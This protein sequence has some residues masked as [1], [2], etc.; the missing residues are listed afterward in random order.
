MIKKF[1]NY[2]SILLLA[3]TCFSLNTKAQVINTEAKLQQYS[4]RI[5]D[6]TKL[7][8]SVHQPIKEHVNFP[9]LADTLTGK[10]QIVSALKPDTTFD[11]NDHTQATI[12]H[13]YIITCFDEGTYTIPPFLLGT[14]GGVLKT[15]DLTLQVKT[16]KV[17]TTK[18]IYDIK[19][20]LVVSYTLW[21]WL[22]DNWILIVVILAILLA[23]AAIIWYLKNRPK[24]IPLI[25]VVKPVIPVHTIALNKLQELRGKKLWQ[26]D[27]K[28]YH[29]ELS[30]ILR[31]YLEK[32][33][34]IKTHEK[35]TD[36]IFAGLKYTDITGENSN[37]LRQILVLADLV[38]FA[39]EKPVPAENEQSMD[40]A[41]DFV[42]KT[43]QAVE[44]PK[45]TEGGSTDEPV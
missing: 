23:I 44:P 16:V 38:K 24:N 22:K 30:D 12:T 27:V 10:V 19:Q 15:N 32:R 36:E 18:A 7:F 31:E 43:Q 37:K 45:T 35:T 4:I 39:K 20:P 41:I 1:F 17:D 34:T 29:S 28:L 21:D 26:Q 3:L 8:L 40:N 11:K 13:S 42:L 25:R 33:Y 6:Q 9:K 5:G 14:S 2:I